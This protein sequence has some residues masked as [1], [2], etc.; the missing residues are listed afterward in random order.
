MSRP[1][2]V[3]LKKTILA[4]IK[5]G[6]INNGLDA[7][8]SSYQKIADALG[9][10]SHPDKVWRL[11]N[12][13]VA[14]GKI[15]VESKGKT[16]ASFFSYLADLKPDS[17]EENTDI[18]SLSELTS[19]ISADISIL[20]NTAIADYLKNYLS[21]SDQT[22]MRNTSMENII[23]SLEPMGASNDGYKFYKIRESEA[24][25]LILIQEQLK[26]RK[27]VYQVNERLEVVK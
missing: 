18:E 6:Y 22:R 25:E 16:S 10:S 24:I 1:E 7:F 8:E 5:H 9:E 13:L 26:Q 14:E 3:K 27:I 15:K 2:N 20:I 12:G 11:C 23:K 21:D 19:Q 4:Y 17:E